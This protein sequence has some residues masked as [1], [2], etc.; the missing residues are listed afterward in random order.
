MGKLRNITVWIQGNPQRREAFCQSVNTIL[1]ASTPAR[2]LILGNVT[3]WTGDYD[4]LE[5]ALKLRHALDFHIHQVIRE[6]PIGKSTIEKDQLTSINWLTLQQ[7]Y[8]FLKP[9]RD[10]THVLEGHRTQGS[11]HEIY[12]SL[13]SLRRHI[14]YSQNHSQSEVLSGPLK[15]AAQKLEKYDSID[16]LSPII[17]ASIVLHPDMDNFFEDTESGWGERSSWGFKAKDLVKTLWETSYKRL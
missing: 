6:T 8:D 10:E 11:L 17:C 3:R 1:G 9:F 14:V 15:L 16:E 12:P 7:T 4:G 5:R 2:S 13:E